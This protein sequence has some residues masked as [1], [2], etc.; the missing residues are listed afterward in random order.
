MEVHF[1]LPERIGGSR[2]VSL[3][4]HRYGATKPLYRLMTGDL[5][6]FHPLAASRNV[7]LCD[8]VR[9]GLLGKIV[10]HNCVSPAGR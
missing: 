9:R 4:S 5:L 10:E 7:V 3:A 1:P 6:N 8:V 2:P